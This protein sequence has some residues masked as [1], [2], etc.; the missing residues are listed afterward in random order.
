MPESKEF[1]KTVSGIAAEV[2]SRCFTA[3][4]PLDSMHLRRLR[5]PENDRLSF[6]RFC[7]KEVGQTGPFEFS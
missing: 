6:K 4:K 3:L 1:L 7:K 2:P 5:P